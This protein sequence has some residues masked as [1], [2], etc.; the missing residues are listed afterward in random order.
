MEITKEYLQRKITEYK[1]M[2]D[3]LKNDSNANNG[4]AQA[5]ELIL[6]ELNRPE[7]EQESK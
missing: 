1:Q 3:K 7:D 6:Q 4:A 5:L 2:A